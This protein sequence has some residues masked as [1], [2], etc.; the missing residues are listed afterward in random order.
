MVT[1]APVKAASGIKSFGGTRKPSETA[2]FELVAYWD[3]EPVKFVFTIRLNSSNADI[4]QVLK[5][6]SLGSKDEEIVPLVMRLLRKM[7]V[8]ND[9]VSSRW[10]LQDALIKPKEKGAIP[11]SYR[12]PDGKIY[13]LTDD[14]TLDKFQKVENGSSRRRWIHL[15][16]EEDD[17]TV[18]AEDVM[19]VLQWAVSE[20]SNRPT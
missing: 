4:I 13:E 19:E 3:D 14:A 15:M 2:D 7:M 10:N 18:E 5:L 11:S 6:Q 17:L 9:G 1:K 20:A 16:E 8:D 12:G